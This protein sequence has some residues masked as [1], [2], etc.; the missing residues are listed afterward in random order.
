MLA[1][2]VVIYG[3]LQFYNCASKSATFDEPL[4][5]TAGYL[6]LHQKEYRLDPTHPPLLRAWA[7]LSLGGRSFPNVDLTGASKLPLNEW[8]ARG[9]ALSR[10]FL[11]SGGE[12]DRL[13]TRARLMIGLF[14][15]GLGVLLFCWAHEWLGLWPAT[16][17]LGLYT[18]EPNLTAHA[19][20]VTTDAGVVCLMF[21]AV[22]FLWRL[23]RRWSCFNL[24]GLT[25]CTALAV[26]SKFSAALLAPILLLLLIVAIFARTS[27]SWR[28]SLAIVAV[29]VAAVVFAIWAVYAFR[30][31]AATTVRGTIQLT[32]NPEVMQ[33]LPALAAILGWI[34]A[35]HLL[36]NAFT[37]G[38][39]W[40][41]ASAQALGAY[42]NGEVSVDGW[43]YYF[44][45]AFLVKTPAPLLLLAAAGLS[46]L[47]RPR[48]GGE[49]V[50]RI[51]ILL[52][53]LVFLGAAMTSRINIGLR[54]ILPLYPYVLLLAALAIHEFLAA[55]RWLGRA[56]VAFTAMVS[57]FLFSRTWPITIA[58][59][60]EFVGGPENGYLYLS[61]SNLDW[62]QH[63]KELRRWM[64][65]ENVGHV[66]LAYFGTVDPASYDIP[67]TNL[68]GGPLGVPT[69]PP[70]LPGYVAISS[71]LL[72]SRYGLLFS[73]FNSMP[74]AA[75]IGYTIR[76]YWV[77]RW[78]EPE[79]EETDELTTSWQ[80]ALAEQLLNETRW[81]E[82]A[83][84]HY[85]AYLQAKNRDAPVWF[86]L[87]V[88][89]Y[90]SGQRPDAL[91]A[92]AKAAAFNTTP[93]RANQIIAELLLKAR[94]AKGAAP[95]VRTVQ[96]K[97][98]DDPQT[99]ELL[100]QFE[101]VQKESPAHPR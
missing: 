84:V 52:P 56:A 93:E 58:Y 65:R 2:F 17:A 1:C 21:G 25:L 48:S 36:P 96:A 8:T 32:A 54:H 22:Y 90:Q 92:F 75:V 28:R 43:W 69:S 71:T 30:Y 34:D 72:N 80:L 41:L 23:Q 86:R 100:R 15:L 76:V 60:N 89:L 16:F 26:V 31:Q 19:G 59:F 35:H 44:P 29:L 55:G 57:L 24:T 61:D 53:P 33:R 64:R 47:L 67:Y 78:P 5:L 73:G 20:L 79:P 39:A 87:G 68:P 62:G 99:F 74:P 18:I 14:G 51:F 66:N 63:L 13:I 85:R 9:Y 88:A 45:V 97:R 38:F 46:F 49:R 27:L 3:C 6:A 98:P 94:D 40:S 42:L 11:F 77:E 10:Q 4:H 50:T 37:Q 101:R 12:G 82:R 95:F 70:R 83:A 91:D 7:A 81:P